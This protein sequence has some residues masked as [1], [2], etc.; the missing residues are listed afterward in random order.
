MSLFRPS[1]AAMRR[2]RRGSL[3]APAAAVSLALL[4]FALAACGGSQST[5]GAATGSS[6]GGLAGAALPPGAPHDFTLV[7]EGGSRVATSEYRGHVVVLAFVG[8]RCGAPCTVIGDQ[9]RGAL[10]D[11]AR[12]VPVLLVTVDPAGDSRAAIARFLASVSLGGRARFLS[13]SAAALRA[14]WRPYRVPAPARGAAI[15]ERFAPVILLDREGRA[16]VEY[17]LEE[18]TP[19]ALAHDIRGLERG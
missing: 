19:E 1:V 10:D 13:G 2:P 9:V 12:S 4:A 18:L 8:T 15:F 17:A 7:D 14:A 3:R 5:T 6:P 16:R 11:L